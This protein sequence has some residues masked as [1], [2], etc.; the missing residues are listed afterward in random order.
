MQHRLNRLIFFTFCAFALASLTPRAR[1]DGPVID[2]VIIDKTKR[3]LMLL[4]GSETVRSYRVALGGEPSGP[5]RRE[6]DQRTPE[7]TYTIDARNPE[8]DFF[9]SLRISYPNEQDQARARAAGYKP[10]GQIMIHGLPNGLGWMGSRYM[11]RDWTDGCIAV[12]NSEMLEIWR[13]VDV[14]TPVEIRP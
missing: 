8:S 12:T 5:K 9:L 2:R 13:L 7:G 1:A 3:T 10:G 11:G 4:N 14:G 6:G